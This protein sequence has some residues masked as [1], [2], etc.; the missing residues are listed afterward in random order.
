M[1]GVTSTGPGTAAPDAVR[2]GRAPGAARAVRAAVA[3]W[4]RRVAWGVVVVAVA[5]VAL[6]GG[7]D[8]AASA[9]G[10]PPSV[11]AGEPVATG[12]FDLTVT[13]WTLT[14]AWDPEGLED[15][16]ADAWLAVAVHALGTDRETRALDAAAVTLP[17][18]L[19]GGLEVV[20]DARADRPAAVVLARDGHGYPQLQ[21][22]L[23]ERVLLL[24]PVRGDVADPLAAPDL[25]VSLPLHVYRDLTVGGGRYWAET[26]A[27]VR[28]RVPAGP[29]PAVLDPSAT[30]EDPWA[31][32]DAEGGA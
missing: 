21:P 11:A 2:A 29:V 12:A 6:A 5:G 7:F 25:T 23:G 10:P 28:V 16:G 17:E 14:D 32:L 20:G 31:A 19:P 26:G 22:G 13:A 4:P 1:R 9:S 27:V 30:V 15:V 18:P 24:W 3:T 8:R